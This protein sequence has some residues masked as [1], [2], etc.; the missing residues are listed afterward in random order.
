MIV[1]RLVYRDFS[2]KFYSD[3]FNFVEFQYKK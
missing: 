3:V 1:Y 2:P